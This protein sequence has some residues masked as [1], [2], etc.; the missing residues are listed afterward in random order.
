MD[1]E[2]EQNIILCYETVGQ[3]SAC[4][5][6]TQEAIVPDACPDI[7][8]IVEVC[9]QA[10]PA[11]SEAGEGQATVVGMI[12]ANVLYLP[13]T[14]TMLQTMPL[15][16]PFSVRLDI[17]GLSSDGILEMSARITRADARLLNP[18]KIL[19][20]CDLLVEVTALHR[21]EYAVSSGVHY[22]E[23]GHI[24]Q[25]QER[26]E[27]E[28]LSAAPR[29]IFPISEEVRLA[30]SQPPVLLSARGSV[31]CTE[32]RVIGSKLIFKGKTEVELLL[33]TPDGETERRVESF[34]FSQILDAKGA[35][36]GGN[37]QVRLELSEFSCVQPLD[38]PFHLMV[39]G[40]I[41]AMGQVRETQEMDILLDLYSTTHEMELERREVHLCGPCQRTV[42]PQTLRDLLET[43]D[44]VRGVCDS[45]FIPGLV[46]SARE[47]D[48]FV[49][50]TH[51]RI[52]VLYLDEERQPRLME[53][54]VEL[55]GRLNC[56][57]G[58]ELIQVTVVPGE[59][60]LS[61]CAG[62]IE[63]RVG[64][65]FIALTACPL[66]VD[67][68]SKATLGELRSTEGVRPSV[69]LRLPEHGESLWDLAKACG[70]TREEIVQANELTNDEIP[71][72]KML[73][74][75]SVR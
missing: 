22:P 49:L 48:A 10:F 70:T 24:C 44:V 4:Q 26:M 43:E 31:C 12:R 16:L 55:T 74:I 41:L 46:L 34:P 38:D 18:R 65:E 57:P 64:V 17:P 68:I 23:R 63:V 14:G 73:L 47:Q 36:E 19:L 35:E 6:E 15:R 54:D 52:S 11:R 5:E 59:L 45:R 32:S 61:P 13:E 71:Q 3:A 2:L 53:K 42:I 51:G 8:R 9:A 28:R 58:T 39:E 66:S 1:F 27:Y 37:C 20:R 50:T 29:R 75:P 60:Y 56:L 30:G 72:G 69:I 40:E 7:L 25:R 67:S 62:G 21:R 33:Q